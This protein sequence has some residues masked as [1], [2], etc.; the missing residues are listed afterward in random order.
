MTTQTGQNFLCFRVK[1]V[2]ENAGS[3]DYKFFIK[4]NTPES[5][6]LAAFV[7]QAYTYQWDVQIGYRVDL[8]Y[9]PGD[10]ECYEVTRIHTRGY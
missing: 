1:G 8:K 4:L 7:Y 9:D 2:H 10:G 5:K 6:S 3:P